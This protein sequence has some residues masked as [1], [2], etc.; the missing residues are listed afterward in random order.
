GGARPGRGGTQG[1]PLAAPHDHPWSSA[2]RSAGVT[3]QD[4]YVE[5]H[6]RGEGYMRDGGGNVGRIKTLLPATESRRE[7]AL[8]TPK[9][10][11]KLVKA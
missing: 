8:T 11:K 7:A 1:V 4:G 5:P 2:A 3:G 6:R 9:D 10:N